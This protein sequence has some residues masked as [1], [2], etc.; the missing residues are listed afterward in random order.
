MRALSR[1]VLSSLVAIAALTGFGSSTALAADSL[2]VTTPYPAIVVGPGSKVSFDLTIKTTAAARVDLSLSGVPDKWTATIRGG[3]FDITAV[4]TDGKNATTASV[5]VTVPNDATGK[6]E[7]VLT[8]QALGQTVTVPL[9]VDVQA[10]AAGTVTLTTDVPAQHGSSSST[11]S[12]NLTLDNETSQDLTFSVVA[13]GPDTSWTVS[14]QLTGS[15]QAA[16]AIVK[17]GSTS[18]VSV[19]VTPPS[20]VTA[21]NYPITVTASAGGKQIQQALEVDIT[22]SYTLAMSTP[23]QVLSTSGPAGSVTE[24]QITLTNN[25]TA[26]IT[27][28]AVTAS[29]P[30]NWTFDFDQKQIASIG[31]GQTVTVTAKITPSSD[32]IAGDYELT[33]NANGDQSTTATQ[34]IRFTVQ[35]SILGGIIGIAIVVVV[36]VAVWFVFRRYGRR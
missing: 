23:N 30:T 19:N 5:D 3:G 13:T 11:F 20:G 26:P 7:M 35:T 24:Q 6:S 25:G 14:A 32:A 17:A 12:F 16:S 36:A 22:G 29:G 10:S 8:A 31:A 2:T 21:G 9:D 28:V 33:F 34:T 18:G 4:Q 15:S 1:T 27:N